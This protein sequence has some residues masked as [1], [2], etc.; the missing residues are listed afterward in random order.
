MITLTM[1]EQKT[2]DLMFKLI[3]GEIKVTD[4]MRLLGLSK[5]QVLRK[6]KAYL[7]SGI[8][9]IPHKSRNKST[10]R[11]Y[12]MELKEEIIKLYNEEYYGWNFHHF[13]DFLEDYHNI[14][15]SDYF[16]YNL[17]TKNGIDSPYKYK[18]RKKAHPPRKRRENA[19][20][21]VQCDASQ[22]PWF[23]EDSTDYYLHGGIDDATG[24]VTAA[25]FAEKETIYGYQ[26]IMYQMIKNYGIPEEL[27]TDFRTIFKY[28]RELTLDEELVGKTL[29][30]TK[31]S[32]MLKNLGVGIISTDNPRAKGRIERL[33]KTF[34][35]RLYKELKKKNI[36]IIKEANE[37]L[38]KIFLPKYNARFASLID[39]TK[40]SFVS[41]DES[42]DYNT[43]L[44]IWDERNILHN[45]YIKYN[46]K[47]HVIYDEKEV[48][49]INTKEKV[50]VYNCL[51]NSIKVLYK[52][53][54]YRTEIVDIEFEKKLVS[55]E[56]KVYTSEELSDLARKR[57]QN[58]PWRKWNPQKI[59]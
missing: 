50:K 34:Q 9:S 14:V 26:M 7:E 21:L 31:F 25:Y 54:L 42:F 13:N 55:K 20:E 22:H 10:G 32:K 8:E 33:W 57:S 40:N 24:I 15:V 48:V 59:F 38:T 11:G 58:S 53:K 27:Y 41:V 23:E 16:I 4:A 3:S 17:L 12:S 18:Q 19:G 36:V 51:D 45:C 2:N 39:N 47:Y 49:Y 37:Y 46:N 52:D 43:E 6:K 5:R 35:D 44:A 30:N 56:K 1:K 29:D 28:K